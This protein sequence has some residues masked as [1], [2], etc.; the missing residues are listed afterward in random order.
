MNIFNLA[1]I[2]PTIGSDIISPKPKVFY[3]KKQIILKSIKNI[4]KT[5]NMKVRRG[6][7]RQVYGF[8]KIKNKNKFH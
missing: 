8:T 5:S 2:F 3:P 4:N 6:F 1:L 7:Q